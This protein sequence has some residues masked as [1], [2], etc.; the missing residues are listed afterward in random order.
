MKTRVRQR[1]MN[2]SPPQGDALSHGL[3]MVTAPVVFGL[4]GA[5][6]D[7]QTHTGPLFLLVFAMFGVAGSFASA[8]YRY[9][10]RVADHD[11]GKPWTRRVTS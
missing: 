2:V 11:V 7:E 10:Q 8:Y 1:A 6:L 4:L 3:A 5:L 9:T